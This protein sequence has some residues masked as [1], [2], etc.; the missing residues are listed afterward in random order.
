MMFNEISSPDAPY[1]PEYIVPTHFVVESYVNLDAIV[2]NA[3]NE[4]DV[5]RYLAYYYNKKY[6]KFNIVMCK[7]TDYCECELNIYKHREDDNY[8]IEMVRLR[9]DGFAFTNIF[10]ALRHKFDPNNYPYS[11]PFGLEPIPL[12]EHMN[13]PLSEEEAFNAIKPI[14]DL[15]N[16]ENL[17]NNE[18]AAQLFLQM[19]EN[20]DLMY[21]MI[22]MNIIKI[23]LDLLKKGKTFK[24]KLFAIKSLENISSEKMMYNLFENCGKLR[25]ILSSIEIC[26]WWEGL[27]SRSALNIISNIRNDIGSESLLNAVGRE[28]FND[29]DLNYML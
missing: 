8:T 29:L 19:T 9:G 24:T 28:V 16:D 10:N 5:H 3:I 7:D 26:N 6:Y 11:E 1:K 14:I 23:L 12:P 2:S 20:K 4:L 22:E 17:H 15:A 13:V 25:L 21:N 27:I 18:M